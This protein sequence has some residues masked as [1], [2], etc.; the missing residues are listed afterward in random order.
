MASGSRS[1][2]L[3]VVQGTDALFKIVIKDSAGAAFDVTA[4]SFSASLKKSYNSTDTINFTVA[5]SDAAAG[6]ISISLSD[7]QTAAL[8]GDSRYVYDLFM[9]NTSGSTDITSILKGKVFVE[10]SVT[11]VT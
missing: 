9:Y 5:V 7:T 3:T 1:E 8:D 6:I 4:K 11:R 2:D 10:S